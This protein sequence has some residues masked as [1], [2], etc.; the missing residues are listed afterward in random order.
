MAKI[1]RWRVLA[2]R[3]FTI[4]ETDLILGSESLMKILELMWECL[5]KPLTLLLCTTWVRPV[6]E[7]NSDTTADTCSQIAVNLVGSQLFVSLIINP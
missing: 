7:L 5:R 2:H 4:R 3:S 6:P 1:L